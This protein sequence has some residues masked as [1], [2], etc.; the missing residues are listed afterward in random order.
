VSSESESG[1]VNQ[2]GTAN[3]AVEAFRSHRTMIYASN[4]KVRQHILEKIIDPSVKH[5]GKLRMPA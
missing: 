2:G 1:G 4:K 3:D 5:G